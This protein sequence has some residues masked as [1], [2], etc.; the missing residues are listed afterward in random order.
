MIHLTNKIRNEIDKG[1]YACEI[2]VDFKKAFDIV[3]H[4]ILQGKLE[5]FGVRGISN[6]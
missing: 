6:K 5:F 2:F 1:N 3:D 4:H